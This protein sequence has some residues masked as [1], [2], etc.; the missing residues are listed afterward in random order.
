M[1]LTYPSGYLRRK[2]G[3]R[4]SI[5]VSNRM[6]SI[7]V[8]VAGWHVGLKPSGTQ[9]YSVWF[10]PLCLGMLDMRT[11]SFQ[12][13]REVSGGG[14]PPRAP[15]FNALGPKAGGAEEERDVA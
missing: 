4:G 3:S 14:A 9:R 8:A 13:V 12:A 6:Y 7:S 1:E 5:K 10:G 2:V 11:E 15:G